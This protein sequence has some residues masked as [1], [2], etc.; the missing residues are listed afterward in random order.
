MTALKGERFA[1]VKHFCMKPLYKITRKKGIL[2]K[3]YSNTF[4][5][6]CVSKHNNMACRGILRTQNSNIL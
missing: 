4:R 1:N 5:L 3:Y 2:L 6:T